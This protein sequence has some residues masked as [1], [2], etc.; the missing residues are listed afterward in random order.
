MSFGLKQISNPT[1][2][3]ATWVFRV[4]LYLSGL[5]NIA[6]IAFTTLPA[7]VKLNIVSW[8]SFATLAV[9]SASKMFGIPLPEGSEIA[10]EDVSSVNTTHPKVN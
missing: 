4:V 5:G 2:A 1:P 8:S 7:D 9:H 10:S 3:M 6:I